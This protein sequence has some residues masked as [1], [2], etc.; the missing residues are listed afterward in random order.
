MADPARVVIALSGG[1]DSSTAAAMLLA[2]G[3]EVIGATLRMEAGPEGKATVAAAQAIADHLGIR[4]HQI[5][6]RGIFSERVLGPCWDAYRSGRTPNPCGLCNPGVKFD[7][8]AALAD[9]LDAAWVATGHHARVDR[10]PPGPALRRG[11]DPDKDQSYFLFGLGPEILSRVRFPVGG[12]TKAQVRQRAREVGLPSAEAPESQDTC[13]ALEGDGFAETLRL[14]FGAAPRPGP[15][16]DDSG[17]ELGRHAGIHRYT[18]GQR[19]GLGVAL[20]QPAWVAAIE[21]EGDRVVVSTDPARLMAGGLVAEGARFG[22]RHAAAES[23]D[24]LVQ[25]RSRHRATQATFN[26]TATDAFE[27]RFAAAQRAISPGQAAVIY[28]GK[29][30][31]AGGWIT[32]A[33]P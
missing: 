4:L 24:C 6:C 15:M 18:I 19:R 12:M 8:L 29:E 3:L 9:E 21:P 20:G 7:Q 5:D 23:G 27:I 25:I 31:V 14:R 11:H 17:A 22:M 30:V 33:L 32:R 16:V 28:S 10:A 2:E 26:R 1:V 13:I